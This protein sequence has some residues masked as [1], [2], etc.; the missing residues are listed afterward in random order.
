MNQTGHV[1]SAHATSPSVTPIFSSQ[2]TTNDFVHP[3]VTSNSTTPNQRRLLVTQAQQV[4]NNI[5]SNPGLI[6]PLNQTGHVLRAHATSPSVT[7]I[8]RSQFTTNDFV[9][10]QVTSN[11]TTPNQRRLLVTQ[12]QQVQNNIL[13]NPS[14][15]AASNQTGHAISLSAS[16]IFRSQCTTQAPQLQSNMLPPIPLSRTRTNA[17]PQRVS[18]PNPF[19]GQFTIYLLQFCPA[20]TSMC[21][22]CGNQLRQQD[23]IPEPPDDLVVVS[24]MLREWTFQGRARSKVSNVYFHCNTNCIKRKQQ[25]FDTRR[26]NPIHLDIQAH[27]QLIHYRHLQRNFGI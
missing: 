3:Q 2:F 9:H 25:D 23:T 5:L 13:P 24:K 21:F 18:F 20:Q 19:P 8:F 17:P 11:S 22:G 12:A 27:L 14:Q 6:A 15:I 26:L 16:P 10:P 7:P 1:Q 4:Q